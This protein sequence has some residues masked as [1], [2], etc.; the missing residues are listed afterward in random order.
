MKKYVNYIAFFVAGIVFATSTTAF[1]DNVLNLVG[2]KVQAVNNISLKDG[3][4]IG[5]GIIVND[6]TYAPVRAVTEAAGFSVELEGKDVVLNKTDELTKE[7]IDPKKAT[8]SLDNIN[9]AIEIAQKNITVYQK[10]ILQSEEVLGDPKYENI[11]ESLKTSIESD[12]EKLKATQERLKELEDQKAKL[13]S[14][15]E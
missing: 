13:E 4:E 5:K 14:N 11:Q 12:K 6:T 3:S 8:P 9:R 15:N 10:S 1:A 7:S 2:S